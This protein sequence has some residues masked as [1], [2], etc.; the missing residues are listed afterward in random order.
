MFQCWVL[1]LSEGRLWSMTGSSISCSFVLGQ[2]SYRSDSES[3]LS[4]CFD[5]R[6]SS[7]ELGWLWQGAEFSSRSL[8][9]S[10]PCPN[11]VL[12]GWVSSAPEWCLFK[13]SPWLTQSTFECSQAV[14]YK[15]K[16]IG[17]LFCLPFAHPCTTGPW[18]I[19]FLDRVHYLSLQYAVQSLHICLPSLFPPFSPLCT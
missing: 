1:L 2:F 13:K 12:D 15:E 7:K 6:S 3:G 11:G 10:S 5:R 4:V 8:I 17:M 9:G 14:I 18:C 19:F 16:V